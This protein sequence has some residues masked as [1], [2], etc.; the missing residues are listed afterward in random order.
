MPHE[1]T[2]KH[3]EMLEA[4]YGPGRWSSMS[5]KTR[6]HSLAEPPGYHV[7]LEKQS[8]IEEDSLETVLHPK[9]P[10]LRHISRAFP[11]TPAEF[12]QT[13]DVYDDDDDVE[14]KHASPAPGR[15][16]GVLAEAEEPDSGSETPRKMA[17]SR[18]ASFDLVH[19]GADAKH[20][21]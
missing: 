14:N 10:L 4:D 3:D 11:E 1:S 21:S 16:N 15:K 12:T 5:N 18:N 19:A 13:I 6:T 2:V 7:R 17:S 8:S 20:H 9:P